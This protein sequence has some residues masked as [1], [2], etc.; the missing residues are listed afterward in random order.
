MR[1]QKIDLPE[2]KKFGFFFSFIFL[3][4][5]IYFYFSAN[6]SLSY[7]FLSF[8]VIFFGVSLCKPVILKPLNKLWF[9]FG[10][11]LSRIVSPIVLGVIFFIILSP[12]AILTRAFGRD[13]LKL[14]KGN[15]DSYWRQRIDS[16]F[17]KQSFTNQF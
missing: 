13:I 10:M 17:D 11:L 5:C 4:A 15:I 7:A 8:S 12:V 3:L 16:D 1:N 9:L 6:Q 2:N 14:K